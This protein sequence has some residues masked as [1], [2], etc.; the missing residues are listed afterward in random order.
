MTHKSDNNTLIED[1]RY[2]CCVCSSKLSVCMAISSCRLHHNI[3]KF[4]TKIKV[5]KFWCF[6]DFGGIFL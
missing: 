5:P 2:L 6:D 4:H 1:N 3:H